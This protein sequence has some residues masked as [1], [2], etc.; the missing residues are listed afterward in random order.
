MSLTSIDRGLHALEIDNN[1]LTLQVAIALHT[2]LKTNFNIVYISI[3]NCNFSQNITNFLSRVAFYN[4]HKKRSEFIYLD[5][6]YL[7]DEI[8]EENISFEEE[9]IESEIMENDEKEG[10]L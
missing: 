4:K 5:F 6:E 1:P 3:Q 2:S 8:K 9:M 10:L 7:Y